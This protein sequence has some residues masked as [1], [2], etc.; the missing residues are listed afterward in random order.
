MEPPTIATRTID[1]GR[2]LSRLCDI[3]TS[4]ECKYADQIE[5]PVAEDELG[6]FRVWAGNVGAHRSGRVSLDYRLREARDMREGVCDLLDYLKII[7]E[8]GNKSSYAKS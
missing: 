5:L 4:E 8:R 1:C 6:R 7:L 2:S 3:L